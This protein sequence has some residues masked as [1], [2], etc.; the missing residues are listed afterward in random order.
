MAN[1]GSCSATAHRVDSVSPARGGAAQTQSG[2][3]PRDHPV[4][5][6][7]NAPMRVPSHESLCTCSAGSNLTPFASPH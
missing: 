4:T 1:A 7:L 5:E 6:L 2:G 3:A